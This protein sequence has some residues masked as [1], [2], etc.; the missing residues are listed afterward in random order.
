MGDPDVRGPRHDRVHLV[1]EHLLA[2]FLGKWARPSV[3]CSMI[4]IAAVDQVPQPA[5]RSG[6]SQ[7]LPNS[8]PL[9]DWSVFP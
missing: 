6:V 3:V 8:F 2:I 7:I 4:V 1:H 9:T 5:E